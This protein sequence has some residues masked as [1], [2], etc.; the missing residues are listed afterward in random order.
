MN[1]STLKNDPRFSANVILKDGSVV[2]VTGGEPFPTDAKDGERE[3]VERAGGF[4][5]VDP[6]VDPAVGIVA[7]GS[8]KEALSEGTLVDGGKTDGV[9]VLVE[10]PADSKNARK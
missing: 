5:P 3:K 10:P 8:P 7:D 2:H 6:V 4:D 1:S 9:N